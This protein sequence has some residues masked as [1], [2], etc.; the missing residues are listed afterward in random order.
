VEVTLSVPEDVIIGDRLVIDYSYKHLRDPEKTHSLHDWVGIFVCP[1]DEAWWA[2]GRGKASDK[3]KD[4]EKG[5][6]SDDSTLDTNMGW[7]GQV[8][9]GEAKAPVKRETGE[10]VVWRF[11]SNPDNAGALFSDTTLNEGERYV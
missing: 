1:D 2:A 8:V 4:K 6:G 5:G 7:T 3:D 10:L 9:Q 11:V